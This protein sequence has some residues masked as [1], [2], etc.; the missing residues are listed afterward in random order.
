MK[1]P[2]PTEPLADTE[3]AAPPQAL[4]ELRLRARAMESG[5][6]DRDALLNEIERTPTPDEDLRARA[7]VLHVIMDDPWLGGF[8][9]SDGR[10]VDAAA[11]QALVNLGEP[12]ASEL[13]PE[14]RAALERQPEQPSAP[15]A[16]SEESPVPARRSAATVFKAEQTP[17]RSGIG[18]AIATVLAA[19]ETL[20]LLIAMSDRPKGD[21]FVT[22]MGAILVLTIAPAW[23][24]RFGGWE[25]LRKLCLVLMTLTALPVVVVSTL[26]LAYLGVLAAFPLIYGLARLVAMY[27]LFNAPPEQPSEEDA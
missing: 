9:G 17:D 2:L 6:D 10:R 19:L 21:L 13:S 7:N 16:S 25:V 5:Q 22:G 11:A 3:G 24:P 4:E 15:A 23:L 14:G 20:L 26:A 18:Q 27:L 1:S 8:A 12:Y